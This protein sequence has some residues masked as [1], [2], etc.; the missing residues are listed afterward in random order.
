[1]TDP[2]GEVTDPMWMSPAD[3]LQAA[4]QKLIILS[5]PTTYVLHELALCKSIEEVVNVSLHQKCSNIVAWTPEINMTDDGRAIVC[6]P[7]D[8]L[9]SQSDGNFNNQSNNLSVNSSSNNSSAYID[10]NINKN[11][12]ISSTS[13][14]TA[15]GSKLPLHRVVK[16]KDEGGW[17]II[18]SQSILSK[19]NL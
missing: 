8:I 17:E 1:M 12:A 10:N 15:Q 19:S 16:R 2:S 7:G 14:V 13:S 6:L 9:H 18:K 4:K 11:H 3:A 5:P